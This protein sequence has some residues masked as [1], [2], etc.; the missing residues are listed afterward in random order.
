MTTVRNFFGVLML[1]VAIYMIS[2]IIPLSLQILLWAALLIIPA[3]YLHALDPLPVNS[4]ASSRL[5]KGI[6]IILLALGLTLVVGAA[7]GAKSPLQPLTGLTAQ[8][9]STPNSALNFKRIHSS[10]ELDAAI[11][12]AKG[13]VVMLDFYA[14]WCVACK[15]LEEFTFSDAGVKNALNNAVLIQADVTNNT[16]DEVAL[17][18]KFKL[19]GPP[20]II[21]FNK[22][23]KEIAPLKVIGYQP[24]QDFI[25]VLNQLNSLGD[26]ECNPTVAC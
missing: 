24:P 21:F 13:K 1:G 8:K 22:S 7:S 10:G 25:K 5:L 9:T 14:D 20:G 3:I 16:A 11:N 23:G 17:L 6:G 26:D 12:N 19:F 18:N 2:P 15:E 4:S